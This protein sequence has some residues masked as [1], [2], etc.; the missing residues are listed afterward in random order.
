MWK[1][2]REAFSGADVYP[3]GD[4]PTGRSHSGFVANIGKKAHLLLFREC[5]EKES[6]TFSVGRDISSAKLI[7]SNTDIDYS[8]NDDGITVRFGKM[9]SYAWF[10]I[11]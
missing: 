6:Y 4:E 3:I 11:T 5:A 2:Y 7:Y 1:N 10:E 9:R 8:Y